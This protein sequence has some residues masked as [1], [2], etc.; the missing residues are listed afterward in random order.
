MGNTKGPGRPT[1]N[2]R[3]M[4]PNGRS[5]EHLPIH[6]WL[7]FVV[8]GLVNIQYMEHLGLGAEKNRFVE[9]P[10][11]HVRLLNFA[12]E[13]LFICMLKIDVAPAKFTEKPPRLAVLL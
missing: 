5:T 11:R 9:I 10:L 4:A 1:N 3:Q 12:W 7:K 6:E 8:N 2:F 13:S